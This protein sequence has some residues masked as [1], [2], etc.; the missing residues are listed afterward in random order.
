MTTTKRFLFAMWDGGG[1]VP[2]ELGVARRL[3]ARGHSVRVLADPTIEPEAR[4]AGCEFTPW[5]TAPHRTSRDRSADIIR[6]YDGTSMLKVVDRYMGEFLGGPAPRWAGDTL[7]ELEARPVDVFLTDQVLPATSIAAE[8]LGIPRAAISPNIWTLPTP[9]IPPLGPGFAPAR[10]P[11]GRLRD[12]IMRGLT[13]R[14]FNK[15]LAPINATRAAY[16]LPPV[17]STHEQM[18]RVDATFVLTSPHFDFTSP[19]LPDTVHFAGP[20]LDDPSWSEPWRSPWRS[21]DDRPLVLVGMSSQFQ[22]H[23]AVMQR[24]VE[25][26]AALPVRAVVTLGPAL[27][28]SEVTGT[29]N[30]H[31]VRSAPHTDILREAS[32]LVTHC[33]H[34]TMMKGLV[35]GVPLLC[36]PM[37]R[38]Q[39]DNAARV[40]HRGAGLRVKTTASVDALRAAVTTLLENGSYRDAARKLGGVIAAR[41]GCVDIVDSLEALA[42][43]EGVAQVEL[44]KRLDRRALRDARANSAPASA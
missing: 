15:A 4:A 27:S 6:D 26:L 40:V 41:E 11:F 33:G 29:E 12:S 8:K 9:G 5:T 30:V 31:V 20:F 35:A 36:V 32:L 22:N 34:G 24:T 39:N 19:A 25:A 43:G 2:P 10:G 23:A 37:G 16:G 7:A 38:D 17:R 13:T 44:H 18:L 3:L 28:P 14:M 42:R 1:T 21:R